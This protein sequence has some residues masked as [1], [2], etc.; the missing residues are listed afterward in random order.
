MQ[1]QYLLTVLLLAVS[2]PFDI[3][4]ATDES[5]LSAAIEAALESAAPTPFRLDVDC[6]DAD[7]NRSLKLFKGSVA[8]WNRERQVLISQEDSAELLKMLLDAGFPSFDARYG[9][10]QKSDKEEA[11]LRVS[12]RIYLRLHD[13]EKTSVQLVD[14]QQSDALL[15]LARRLLDR[16]EKHAQDGITVSGL[17]DGLSKLA[18]KVLVPEVLNLRLLWLPADGDDRSGYILQLEGG[19][20]SRQSYMPGEAI[21]AE[22]KRRLTRCEADKLIRV[23]NETRVWELPAN[24]RHDGITELDVSVLGHRKSVIARSSFKST[25]DEARIAFVALLRGLETL[26][27]Q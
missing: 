8:I 13:L 1:I 2:L 19:E 22:D 18:S 24:L 21:G 6:T 27:C 15:G 9:G 11:P 10:R 17:Q 14:G 4:A 16:V 20:L 12:C 7:A 26:S 5:L 25:G 3:A 23:L